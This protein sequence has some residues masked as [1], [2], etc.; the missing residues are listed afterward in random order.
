MDQLAQCKGYSDPS[1]DV[2]DQILQLLSKQ[3]LTTETISTVL[4]IPKHQAKRRLRKLR[5][6]RAVFVVTRKEVFF[7]GV[8]NGGKV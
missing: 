2:D 7:W 1:Q 6:Y 5:R 8:G 3:P 4:H